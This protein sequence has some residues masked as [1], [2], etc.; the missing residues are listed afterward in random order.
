MTFKCSERNFLPISFVLNLR[1]FSRSFLLNL[2]ATCCLLLAISAIFKQN[3]LSEAQTGEMSTS[4]KA[5][6][7]SG[8][9][10]SLPIGKHQANVARHVAPER[11]PVQL[12]A[13]L[14]GAIASIGGFMFGYESGQIGGKF[15]HLVCCT[16]DF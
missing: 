1:D 2:K 4:E 12:F 5:T 11:P 3:S 10:A 16:Q 14:L 8:S 13:V 9:A 7:R 6:P 15:S